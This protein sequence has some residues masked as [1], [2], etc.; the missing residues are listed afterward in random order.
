MAQKNA[1]AGKPVRNWPE[2]IRVSGT[3]PLSRD[4]VPMDSPVAGGIRLE[5][6]ILINKSASDLFFFWRDFRNL[7]AFTPHLKSVQ[8]LDENRS[9][10]TVEGPAG[11]DLS[12]EARLI[13][14][15]PCE[16]I[17]WRSYEGSDLMNAGSVQF[18]ENAEGQNTEVRLIFS[19]NPPA[20]PVGSFLAKLS[21]KDP[22]VLLKE[23]LRRFKH[24]ME[25]GMS[26]QNV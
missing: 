25:S 10:W 17:S 14:D 5:E 11:K 18:L 19:Y 2:K 8:I 23:Q 16:V 4:E 20:G 26:N 15:R 22:A 1:T 3:R 9:R 21:G 13:E 7:P 12:W 24:L 6:S